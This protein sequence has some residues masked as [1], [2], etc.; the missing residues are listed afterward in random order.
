MNSPGQMSEL[1]DF[2]RFAVREAVSAGAD[3]ADVGVARGRSLEVE[4]QESAVVSCDRHEGITASVRSFVRGGCGVHICH[5]F[6]RGDL[7]HAARAAVSAAGA[8]GPDPDFRSLPAPAPAGMVP[9]L[10]DDWVGGV[11][12]RDAAAIARSCIERALAVADDANV[13]GALSFVSSEGAF[14]SSLGIEAEEQASSVS[15]ELMC[16]IKRDG[17][18]GSYSEFDV[19]RR[20]GDVDLESVGEAVARAALRY[21]G[22]RKMRGGRMPCVFGPLAS[23]ALMDSVASA[24]SAEPIQRGRSFLCGRLGGRIAP[25]AFT[26]EDD[27]RFPAGLHSSSRDGEGTPRRPL[28]IV[29]KGVFAGELHNSYTAGKSGRRGARSTGHGTQLGGIAPTNLRPRV[30]QRPARELIAETGDGLYVESLLLGPNPVTGD[31]SAVVDWGMRIEG[32]ELAWPV[33]GVAISGNVLELLEDLD[34]VSSDYRE[35]PG[36]I[37]P[38]LRFRKI[39]VAGT[40]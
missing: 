2:A 5:G 30:G 13:S 33:T 21:L 6:E 11:S 34:E 28:L 29:E 1:L 22:S 31:I 26:L 37:M 38:T 23:S 15:T 7:V 4:I 10:Y 17:K 18:T 24:A 3:F 16:V 14:V 9:D 32:G 20:R 8:A 19:G 39:E 40:A 36:S 12:A 27:G 25:G 35:E